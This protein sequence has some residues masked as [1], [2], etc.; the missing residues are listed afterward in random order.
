MNGKRALLRSNSLGI[1]R[2][3]SAKFICR[4]VVSIIV[5]QFNGCYLLP[6]QFSFT[7]S[8]SA[9]SIVNAFVNKPFIFLSKT[10]LISP[11][12][13]RIEGDWIFKDMAMVKPK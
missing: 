8:K 9:F 10:K 13:K 12:A 6:Y 3:D 1:I 4:P 5:C 7:I 11:R 2:S